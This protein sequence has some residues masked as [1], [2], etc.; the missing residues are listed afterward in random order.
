VEICDNG[1]N[2]DNDGQIVADDSDC[3]QQTSSILTL[4]PT[5]APT[6]TLTPT[7]IPS[8]TPAPTNLQ[9]LFGLITPSST[10]TPTPAL[11]IQ[12]VVGTPEPDCI[13]GIPKGGNITACD[14]P[15][16]AQY[17][18]TCSNVPREAIDGGGFQMECVVNKNACANADAFVVNGECQVA[19]TPSSQ[20]NCIAEQADPNFP[21]CPSGAE[22]DPSFICFQ[23]V[24]RLLCARAATPLPAS[25]PSTSTPS[26][27]PSPT[28]TPVIITNVNNNQV[29][30]RNDGGF[31]VQ[32]YQGA[33]T[34]T[35]DCPPQS[36]TV[37][38]G[39]STMENGGARILASFEP[40]VLADG[41]VI[42]NL[43][44]EQGI[45]LVAA[46]I[47]GG[48]T[49]QSVVVPMQR[50]A[51]ITQGQTLYSVDL[52]GQII[53]TD[54][55]TGNPVTLNGNINALF[56]FNNGGQ[57]VEFSGDNSVALNAVL[58]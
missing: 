13:V 8:P 28:P 5:P 24:E 55:A 34:T 31:T 54:P 48:Q 32:N 16:V 10:P 46:N 14:D 6:L 2:D 29:T 27:S 43:P 3:T 25:I 37:L 47:H 50:V 26:P 30:V 1:L 38:L 35:P 17:A 22:N 33:L 15:S 12:G 45:Q 49:T 9:G 18:Q 52:N 41:S 19:K 58:R 36:P 53:G 20:Y 21:T 44:D 56:L 4:T 23:Q 42:L 57:N 7:L 40:C 11:T 51:P 39:P